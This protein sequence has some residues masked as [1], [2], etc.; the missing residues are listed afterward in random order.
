MAGP[1]SNN[2]HHANTNKQSRI[3]ATLQSVFLASN[4]G[5][6]VHKPPPDNVAYKVFFRN[7]FFQRQGGSGKRRS[8]FGGNKGR[9]EGMKA[10]TGP[11]DP[12]KTAPAGLKS[13]HPKSTHVTHAKAG[14]MVRIYDSVSIFIVST[15]D[16][17]M[18]YLTLFYCIILHL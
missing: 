5:N 13:L 3:P 1:S 15:S 4:R 8:L 16:N 6:E 10:P 11:V 9:N 14:A 18:M 12:A 2:H 7:W 17:N